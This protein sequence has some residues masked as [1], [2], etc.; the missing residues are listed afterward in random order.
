MALTAK[1]DGLLRPSAPRQRKNSSQILALA[2]VI[3]T[4]DSIAP[5]PEIQARLL[6]WFEPRSEIQLLKWK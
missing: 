6:L 5:K 2:I 4:N 3:L 1:I